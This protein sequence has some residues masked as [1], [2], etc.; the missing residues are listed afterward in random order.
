MAKGKFNGQTKT[1]IPAEDTR[2]KAL[3]DLSKMADTDKVT[4]VSENRAGKAVMGIGEKPVTFDENGKA[5]VSAKEAKYF[6]TIPGFE[7]EGA[8]EADTSTSE[9]ETKD[10]A[11]DG[12]GGKTET[13]D[14]ES[15]KKDGANADS[16]KAEET[17]NSEEAGKA[18]DA[19]NAAQKAAKGNK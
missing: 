6:L 19:T 2:K 17:K 3:S 5:E 8:G 18:A 9:D 10:S 14:A 15:E 11:K 16:A 7:L 13:P 4:I 12:A 1:E